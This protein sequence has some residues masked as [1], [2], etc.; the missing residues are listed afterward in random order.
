[1]KSDVEFW[2]SKQEATSVRGKQHSLAA[3]FIVPPPTLETDVGLDIQ[4]SRLI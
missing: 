1:M 2:E 4:M 3:L